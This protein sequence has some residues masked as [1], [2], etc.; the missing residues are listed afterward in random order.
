[1]ILRTLLVIISYGCKVPAGIFVPSMAIGA[2][3]G[4]AVGI[5]VEMLQQSK[6]DLYIFSSCEP[7]IPVRVQSLSLSVSGEVSSS[8]AFGLTFFK[9]VSHLAHMRFW[10]PLLL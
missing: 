2:T 7:D 1:M 5:L 9:S 8:P 3:F 10:V 6:P 4:R